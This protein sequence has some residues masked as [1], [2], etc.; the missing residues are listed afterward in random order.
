[1]TSGALR[2]RRV[3]G[4]LLALLGSGCSS[5]LGACAG[6]VPEQFE[7]TGGPAGADNRGEVIEGCLR[8]PPQTL[9][10]V[11]GGCGWGL[12]EA[13]TAATKG[14]VFELRSLRPKTDDAPL[15]APLPAWCEAP[16]RCTIAAAHVGPRILLWYSRR[17]LDP[18]GAATREG[19]W[20]SPEPGAQAAREVADPWLGP[21]WIDRGVS[22]GPARRWRPRACG[23]GVLFEE[24]A[25]PSLAPLPPLTIRRGVLVGDRIVPVEPP[26]PPDSRPCSDVVFQDAARP[27]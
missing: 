4:C 8:P 7:A 1:M 9:L 24:S 2:C 15:M 25:H 16:A 11:G 20:M 14:R 5:P 19:L 12:V 18:E 21:P 22:R 27:L 26:A 17:P 6:S 13:S 23:G 3:R 10:T